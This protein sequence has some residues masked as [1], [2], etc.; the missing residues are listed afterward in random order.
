V[1]D[2][3]EAR[4]LVLE[5]GDLRVALIALDLVIARPVLRD[6]LIEEGRQMGV[7]SVMLVATHT[8]SGPG[9]YL[10]GWLSERIT[11]GRYDPDTPERLVRAAARA[12]GRAVG[13][14]SP[15]RVGAALG[16]CDLSENRRDGAKPSGTALPVLRIEDRRGS[17]RRALFAYAAHPTVLSPKSHVYSADYPGAAR[18]WLEKEG[19]E[20]AFLPG[21]LGDQRP[22]SEL[23]PEWPDDLAMQ[24]AQRETVGRR[25]GE[26]VLAALKDATPTAQ[27][28]LSA[29][30]RWV[31][32]PPARFRRGCL[33][34]WFGPFLGRSLRAFL[35][36]RVPLHAI[37]VG[38]TM[39]L[40][41][42]GEP[43][44]AVGKRL[45]AQVSGG[46][47]TFIVSHANDWIG[48]VVTADGYRDGGYEACFSFHGPDFA[49]WLVTEVAETLR[50]LS[51]R[52]VSSS[53][54]G[55]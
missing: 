17:A 18:A 44:A 22:R 27:A 6:P 53:G 37:Q 39:L 12:M 10:E 8:H 49:D 33:V 26:A 54:V 7:D 16:Q 3:P 43:T 52:P 13:D 42:P 38:Q 4:A 32:L 21:A 11:A 29:V 23:G 50:L 14:L 9:G 36:P 2:P 40:A 41:V 34:W 51:A 5:Q 55:P 20:A 15:A 45:R 30:E 24:K 47:G 1:L 25:L 28:P 46:E 19:W 48:Y 35:S 31:E